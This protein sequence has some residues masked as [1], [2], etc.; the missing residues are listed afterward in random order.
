MSGIHNVFPPNDN[1]SKDPILEKKLAKGGGTHMTR[2]MLLGFNF[3]GNEKTMWLEA[4]KQKKHLTILKGWIQTDARGTA[5]IP[6]NEF[7]S[8]IAKLQ[9]AFTCMPAGGRLLS[10]CNWVLMT[11]PAFVYLHKND[12]LLTAV[13]GC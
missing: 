8:T 10:P 9:H 5:G 1:N 4:E 7:A 11:R 12:S 2:K 6:F 13:K 3:N